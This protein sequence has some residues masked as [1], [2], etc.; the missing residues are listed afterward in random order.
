MLVA[1]VVSRS[2]LRGMRRVV[3]CVVLLL[4]VGAVVW[5]AAAVGEVPFS[6]RF[7]VN[8][9]GAIWVTG[10]TLMTCPAAAA[11]CAASQAGTA[12]GAALSN[13]AYAM[14]PVDVDA[15]PATFNS[16][17]STFTPP[18]AYEVLFAG[19]Y[20]G[21]RVTAGG[22]GGAPAPN[23]AARGTALLRTPAGA[24][25]V[26]VTGTVAD[27]TVVAGSYVAFADVTALV[28]RAAPVAT[29][30]ATCRAAPGRTGTPAGRW[31]WFTAIRRSR[32]AI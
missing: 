8:E 16:S 21:G 4:G 13:N 23:A 7:S 1:P 31:S 3:N 9:P 28:R 6:A 27:S 32:C 25:Y 29:T 15:D 17:S 22:G 24:G 20:F 26:P 2:L 5:P 19:L 14:V 11:N 10:S 18:A 30:S 12:T